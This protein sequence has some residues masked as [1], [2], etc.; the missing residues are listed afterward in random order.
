MHDVNATPMLR[1]LAFTV[2]AIVGDLV[3]RP[4]LLGRG[5]RD[6]LEQHGDADAAPSGRPRAVLHGDVVVGHDRDDPGA[7]LGRGHLG[8]HLEVHDVAGVVLDDV[9]HAGAAVD[10]LGG[11]EHL[12]GH[13]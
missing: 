11:G 2:R 13:R 12:V 6:L 5:T 9:Q 3:E 8:R 4:V 10:E 1:P 7:R